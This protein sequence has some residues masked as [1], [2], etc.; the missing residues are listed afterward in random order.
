MFKTKSDRLN[1]GQLLT[2]PEGYVFEKAIGTTYSLDLET[3][4]AIAITF[5]L[6]EE[7]DSELMKNPISMLNALQK[8]SDKVLLFCEAGQIKLPSTT[9]PLCLLLE[10]MVVQVALGYDKKLKRYPAFHPKTWVIGFKGSNGERVYRFIVLSRNLTFDRSWDISVAIDGKVAGNANAQPV[11]DFLAFLR[12]NLTNDSDYV[13]NHRKLLSGMMRELENVEFTTNDKAFTDFQ[14][15]PMGI[16]ANAYEMSEDNLMKDTFHEVLV[17]SPFLS[18]SIIKEWNALEKGLTNCKRTLITRRTELEKISNKQASNFDVFVLKDT[19]IDGEEALS[20]ESLDK[21]KQDIHAKLYLRRKYSDIDLYLGSMN[22]SYAAVNKNVEM[23]VRLRTKNKYLNTDIFLNELF[24]GNID[25]PGN[26]F[27]KVEPEENSN[28]KSKDESD[29]LERVIKD[30]CRMNGKAYVK[31]HEEKYDIE[32]K[33]DINKKMENV[34]ISPLRSNKTCQIVDCVKFEQMDLLQ[35]SEFYKIKVVGEELSLE[36]VIM[37]PTKGIP[38]EREKEVVHN[39]VKD[40]K[41]FIDYVVFVLG[42]DYVLSMMEGKYLEE[43]GFHKGGGYSMPAVYEKMLKTALESPEK[44]NEI[45]YLMKTL[46][47][48]DIVPEEFRK[49]Y[50]TFRK[51]LKL[52]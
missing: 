24:D 40:K 32:I 14:I 3:L 22:A 17:M 16:G 42:E 6:S 33:F 34:Y 43:N 31:E 7:T 12:K 35:L 20:D 26:P 4:T 38:E 8:V 13:K 50:E 30:I 49:T 37:I 52:K 25:S 23:M 36:R 28:E 51:T 29:K 47:D 18:G 1:Y 10:K 19:V 11:I 9:T 15:L 21:Q 48:V 27:Q 5:G 45:N 2:P 44:L 41:S 46:D 39:I